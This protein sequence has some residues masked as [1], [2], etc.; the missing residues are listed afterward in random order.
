MMKVCMTSFDP[1]IIYTCWYTNHIVIDAQI[2][3]D[4]SGCGENIRKYVAV[5]LSPW[6]NYKQACLLIF[7][8]FGR[9]FIARVFHSLFPKQAFKPKPKRLSS[10]LTIL[11]WLRISYPK[12]RHE[13]EDLIASSDNMEDAMPVHAVNLQL[14]MTFFIPVVCIIIHVSYIDQCA[15]HIYRWGVYN[16]VYDMYT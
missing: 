10:V 6:H 2:L 12:W 8:K 7:R 16:A 9:T 11:Q 13:L 4:K 15:Q 1:A 14:M 3:Y 5:T